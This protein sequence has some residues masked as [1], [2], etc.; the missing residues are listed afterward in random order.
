LS[1]NDK[2][3]LT[4]QS[5]SLRDAVNIRATPH[6]AAAEVI[7]THQCARQGIIL[8]VSSGKANIEPPPFADKGQ[9]RLPVTARTF[10]KQMRARQF[11]HRAD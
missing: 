5:A 1:E 2:L 10:S 11:R 8:G 3:T 7:D 9:T 4:E 6:E